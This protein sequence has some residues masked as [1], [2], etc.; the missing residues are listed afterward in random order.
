MTDIHIYKDLLSLE[1]LI[2][3]I[4]ELKFT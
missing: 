2:E 3:M 1:C 4:Y